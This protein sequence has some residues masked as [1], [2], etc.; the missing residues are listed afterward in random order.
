[1]IK[2]TYTKT[3]WLTTL[4]LLITLGLPA[5]ADVRLAGIFSSDMVL[6]R[7]R[8]IVIWGWADRGE[9][10]SITFN[11]VTKRTKADASGKWKIVL[12]EMK[13]GGPHAME[14]RGKNTVTLNNILIGDLWICSAN[15][16]WVSRSKM[17]SIPR[18]RLRQRAS[19]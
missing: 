7:D 12:P 8:A 16:T 13:A 17:R 6:Q 2:N 11:N 3:R 5:L 9:R 10:V 4:L 15:P 18:W 19:P 14:V 1:M